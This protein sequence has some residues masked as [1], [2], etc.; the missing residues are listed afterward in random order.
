ML[1]SVPGASALH[2]ATARGSAK[3]P[4]HSMQLYTPGGACSARSLSQVI[5]ETPLTRYRLQR[6]V[7][8]REQDLLR[9]GQPEETAQ[10][11]AY[12]EG[13]ASQLLYLQ[14]CRLCGATLQSG[15]DLNCMT[16]LSMDR[17]PGGRSGICPTALY[18]LQVAS[19]VCFIRKN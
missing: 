1:P 2:R 9:P 18:Q 17:A 3:P 16:E 19:R 4:L 11:E 12:A 15:F 13:T 5:A 7:D 10:L 14:V 6:I 8:A